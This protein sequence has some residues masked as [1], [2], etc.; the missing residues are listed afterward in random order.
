MRVPASDSKADYEAARAATLG[1]LAKDFWNNTWLADPVVFG[2]YPEDGLKLYGA[3]VPRVHEGDMETIRQPLDFYGINVY[4]AERYRAGAGG[5]GGAGGKPEKVEYPPGQPRTAINWFI[6]P[7]ALYYGAKFLYERYKV[8]IVVTENGMSS[9]DWVGLD[10]RVRDPQRIDYTRRYLLG[11]ERAMEEGA[12]VRG[13]FHWSIMDNFEWQSGYKE[14]FGLVYVDF[15]T[16]KRTLKDSAR[17]YSRVIASNGGELRKAYTES[18]ERSTE[19][20]EKK[21][22]NAKGVKN[23]KGSGM[24]GKKRT[25]RVSR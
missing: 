10:G 1:V 6:E 11:L 8:P 22:V 19:G 24:A 13:Y 16:Q 23:S 3:D 20:T 18:T 9:H 12:D 7:E 25:G 4:D 2:R 21:S 5:V 15:A 17:W 14:R